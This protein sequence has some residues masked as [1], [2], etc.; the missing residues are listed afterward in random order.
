MNQLPITYRLYLGRKVIKFF[1]RLIA[2]LVVF[3][4]LLLVVTPIWLI[5]KI[6]NPYVGN[7]WN[8]IPKI[9]GVNRYKA[10]AKKD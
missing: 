1:G 6:N 2:T 7:P 5:V 4:I 8:I 9:W 10:S 3:P